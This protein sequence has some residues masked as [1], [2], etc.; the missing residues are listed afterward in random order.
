MKIALCI[1]GQP[2]NVYRGI[3]NI[4]QN[5]K[6]DFDVFAHAWWDRK[7]HEITFKKRLWNGV[8]DEVSDFVQND[9]VS[10][11]YDNFDV[12]KI[13]LEEQKQFDIPPILEKRKLKFTNTFNVCSGLYGVYKCNQL[14]KDYELE[15]NFKYDWVVRTRYD[16]GLSE[17]LNIDNFDNNFIYAPSDNSHNYGFNDQFAIGSS[18]DM[19]VYSNAFLEIKQTLESHNPGIYTTHYCDKPDNMGQEQLVQRYLDNN[20]IKFKTVDFKNFLF[21]DKDK[22][23]R[24]HSIED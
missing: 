18:F 6:F 14:K 22:R 4:L 3:E 23:T 24:I 20:S 5:M 12:K 1:S 11:M 21:R 19:D 13:V 2:R 9:W 8:D 10:K 15:N 7:S 17:F 16:F